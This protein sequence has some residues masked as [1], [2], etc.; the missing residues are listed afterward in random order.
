[1][2]YQAKLKL[3]AKVEKST[4]VLIYLIDTLASMGKYY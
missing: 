3:P 4:W 1:M 2:I